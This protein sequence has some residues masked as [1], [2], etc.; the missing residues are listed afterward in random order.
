M[1]PWGNEEGV[2][3]ER[4]ESPDLCILIAF[5]LILWVH[6]AHACY[7]ISV[8]VRGQLW[9]SDFPFYHGSSEDRTQTSLGLVDQHLPPLRHLV[10]HSL[11]SNHCI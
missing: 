7:E 5:L 2:R 1:T 6:N 3:Q 11:H 10:G 8:E 4:Q 9:K